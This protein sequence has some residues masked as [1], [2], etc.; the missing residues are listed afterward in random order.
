MKSTHFLMGFLA[1]AAA[2]TPRV[3]PYARSTDFVLSCKTDAR[4]TMC[5]TGTRTTTCDYDGTLNTSDYDNCG[6]MW[7]LCADYRKPDAINMAGR[8]LLLGDVGDVFF[9]QGFNS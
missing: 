3:K 7:C 1:M 4:Y 8:Q 9:K 2:T 5:T 6:P